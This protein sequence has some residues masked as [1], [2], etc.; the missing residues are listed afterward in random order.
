MFNGS[1]PAI[2][3]STFFPTPPAHADGRDSRGTPKAGWQRTP[4]PSSRMGRAL[5]RL[6]FTGKGR[7]RL[8]LRRDPGVPCG[9]LEELRWGPGWTRGGGRGRA[10]S[11]AAEPRAAAASCL[12]ST[13]VSFS[14]FA[15]LSSSC[16]DTV[17][18][19]APLLRLYLGLVF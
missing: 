7:L 17:F 2:T 4:V 10:V 6:R 15:V 16:L 9:D 18:S 11:P 12:F 13:G 14:F 3:T 8:K 1:S 19:H 5:N